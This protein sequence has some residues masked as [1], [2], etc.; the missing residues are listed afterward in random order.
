[1]IVEPNDIA[2]ITT[3]VNQA[4]KKQ[5]YRGPVT[6]DMC[7][8]EYSHE[9]W[10]MTATVTSRY[11]FVTYYCGP[12]AHDPNWKDKP[13]PARVLKFWSRLLGEEFTQ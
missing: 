12:C 7:G 1:M 9:A 6:C 4:L 11:G 8:K 5:G 3:R 13:I 2:E 10:Q